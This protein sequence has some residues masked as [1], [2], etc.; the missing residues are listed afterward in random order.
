MKMADFYDNDNNRKSILPDF[1]NDDDRL[2]YLKI[3]G[4]N[5]HL[6][7]T[8]KKVCNVLKKFNEDLTQEARKIKKPFHKFDDYE[9]AILVERTLYFH[10]E[11]HSNFIKTLIIIMESQ[12]YLNKKEKKKIHLLYNKL[13][14]KAPAEPEPKSKSNLESNVK[15]N[16]EKEK[17]NKIINNYI[18]KHKPGLLR[19]LADKISNYF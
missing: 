8:M 13:M 19:R 10:A 11:H 14:E 5:G 15:V 18:H 7:Y 4:A 3:F 9:I 17:E 16:K 6:S 12:E 2:E 1:E